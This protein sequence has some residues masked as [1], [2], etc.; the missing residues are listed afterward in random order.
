MEAEQFVQ[1]ADNALLRQPESDI[2]VERIRYDL[3]SELAASPPFL[4][5]VEG[6]STRQTFVAVESV[7]ADPSFYSVPH[8]PDVD[9]GLAPRSVPEHLCRF[10]F[11]TTARA[12]A[13][14]CCIGGQD[15]LG[16]RCLTE[17]TL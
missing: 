1:A 5:G 13:L 15:P 12:R 17:S 11:W 7:A 10:A 3:I 4:L 8:E 2:L 6:G 9:D 14:D 16:P